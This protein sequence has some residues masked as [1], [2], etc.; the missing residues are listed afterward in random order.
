[1]HVPRDGEDAIGQVYGFMVGGILFLAAIAGIFAFTEGAGREPVGARTAEQS[2]DA[3]NLVSLVIGSAGSGWSDPDGLTRFGLLNDTGQS[4][5]PHHLQLLNA[6][7]DLAAQDNGL[8]DYEEARAALG[9]TGASGFRMAVTALDYQEALKQHDFSHIKALYI[10]DFTSLSTIT[11]GVGQGSI[12]NGNLGLNAS[13]GANTGLERTVIDSIGVDFDNHVHMTLATPSIVVQITTI[14]PVT[15]PLLP[16][17]GLTLYDGD[18]L[19]DNKQYLDAVLPG[20]LSLG[21]YDLLILGSGIDHSTLTANSVK[22][23]IDSFVRGGGTMMVFGSPGGNFNWMQP[24]M[25]LS[26][27]SVSGAVTAVHADHEI[28]TTPWDLNWPAYPTNNLAWTIGVPGNFENILMQGGKPVVAVSNDGAI[29]SGNVFLSSIQPRAVAASLGAAEASHFMF[30]MLLYDRD[31][32]DDPT[33]VF[34]PT[35]PEGTPVSSARRTAVV[36]DGGI[37]IPVRIELLTWATAN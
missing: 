2:I 1:M 29:G 27:A 33:V 32:A 31:S 24:I 16:F 19:Y 6:G 11:L 5:D 26:A 34:G 23:S 4:L 22:S 37:E 13:M 8:L 20:K 21:G 17:L 10:G 18:V 28:L 14:P 36:V 3:N 35:P 25:D 15:T 9:L 7:D 12:I 30:N